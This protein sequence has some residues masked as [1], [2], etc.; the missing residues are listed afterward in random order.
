MS[1][2]SRTVRIFRSA[3]NGW[4]HDGAVVH[5]FPGARRWHKYSIITYFIEFIHE[6]Y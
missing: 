6:L 1:N 5:I 2:V 3:H 4:Q